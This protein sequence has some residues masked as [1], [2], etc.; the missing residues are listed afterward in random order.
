[1]SADLLEHNFGCA[2]FWRRGGRGKGRAG[3]QRAEEVKSGL[4]REDGAGVDV[5][6]LGCY[7]RRGGLN[8]E[9][10]ALDAARGGRRVVVVD[11]KGGSCRGAT[12]ISLGAAVLSGRGLEPEQFFSVIIKVF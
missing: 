8:V 5:V 6:A 2:A 3:V 4:E 9:P 12:E 7:G 1:M 10:A 11:E